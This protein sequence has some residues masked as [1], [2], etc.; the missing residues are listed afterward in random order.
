MMYKI[1]EKE[2]TTSDVVS[3]VTKYI[4]LDI[5]KLI[6]N[7][8]N[9]NKKD[10]IIQYREMLLYGEEPIKIVI[11]LAN[12]FRLMYQV[13]EYSKKG[14]SESEIASKLK[15]HPYRVKLAKE[16]AKSY[17]S[18]QLLSYLSKLADIDY[19]IKNGSIEKEPALEIF[20]MEV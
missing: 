15:V 20:I 5:F 6:D 16:K 10:A 7:I 11:T 14:L 1:N 17:K 13:K 19:Q 2:I 3:V 4:D 12:Q 8:V 9:K 18:E